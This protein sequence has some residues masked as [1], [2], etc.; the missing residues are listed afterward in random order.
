M[1]FVLAVQA[2][3]ND[4]GICIW[5]IGAN[6]GEVRVERDDGALLALADGGDGIVR[7]KCIC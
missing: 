2:Q 3:H 6:I 5:R 4:A 7:T 1:R